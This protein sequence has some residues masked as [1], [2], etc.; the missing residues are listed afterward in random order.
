MPRKPRFD[1]PGSW[2]HVMNRAISK[3]TLFESTADIRFFLSRLARSIRGG[4]LEVH[5]YTVLT[6]HFHLLVRSPRGR[7]SEAMRQ[8]QNEYVRYFNRTRRRDGPLVRGR[9]LSK[10]VRSLVYRRTLVRYIDANAV[11][12]GLARRPWEYRHGSAR[13]HL[14]SKSPR[15]LERSWIESASGWLPGRSRPRTYMS[16]FRS[17]AS[18]PEWMWLER[19]LE[20]EG[21]ADDPLDDLVGAAA[22]RVLAWMCKKARLADGSRPGLPLVDAIAIERALGRERS[23]GELP[24][25]PGRVQR[26]GWSL[27]QVA[28]LRDLAG[29]TFAE[30]G[31][32]IGR[33]R[34][35]AAHVYRCHRQALENDDYATRLAELAR[36]CLI[37]THTVPWQSVIASPHPATDGAHR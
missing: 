31:T 25:K 5:A 7:L 35:N 13:H 20:R 14:A 21:L 6:T 11:R 19:R 4:D 12:A 15:W 22:P 32:R 27:A 37:E 9:F 33:T 18:E 29:Q 8:I 30:I 1:H 36:Q 24:V 28:L 16:F 17:E 10:P 26:D 23:R 3:R 2:H 34:E